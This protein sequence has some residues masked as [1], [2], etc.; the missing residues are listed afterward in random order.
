MPGASPKIAL[1]TATCLL[2]RLKA[3]GVEIVFSSSKMQEVKEI[4]PS[5]LLLDLPKLDFKQNTTITSNE[6]LE[7]IDDFI[8]I[9]KQYGKLTRA[10]SFLQHQA[11]CPMMAY[12]IHRLGAKHPAKP[13]GFLSPLKRGLITHFVL[14]KIYA[15]YE[16][17]KSLNTFEVKKLQREIFIK[18]QQ[19]AGS[20]ASSWQNLLALEAQRLQTSILRFI[21]LD[22]K[23]DEFEIVARELKLDLNLNGFEFEV[24]LDR[25]DKLANGE[26]VV[27]DYKTGYTQKTGWLADRLY[28]P[29]LPLYAI[30]FDNVGTIAFAEVKPTGADFKFIGT[31]NLK[32]SNAKSQTEDEWQQQLADWQDKLKTLTDEIHQGVATLILENKDAINASDAKGFCRALEKHD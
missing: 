13:M 32:S 15:Q 9:E 6:S 2:D 24:R 3:N 18:L 5:P 19:E 28:E 7:L 22:K 31:A 14:D 30:N 25:V 11:I 26:H 27:I 23:R 1:D 16:N 20:S 4:L 29:Q 12:A 21:E 17:R 10:V 8:G